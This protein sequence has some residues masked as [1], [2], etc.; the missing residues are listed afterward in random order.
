MKARLQPLYP[1]EFSSH[2]IMP[3]MSLKLGS[4]PRRLESR[5]LPMLVAF[6]AAANGDAW[7]EALLSAA[8]TDDTHEVWGI[9]AENGSALRATAIIAYLPF[10]AELQSIT[11]WP[12]ARRR[13]LAQGLLRWLLD[14]ARQRGVERLLL[15]VRESNLAARRLYERAGF[16]IDGQRR[17]YYRRADGGSEDAVLMSFELSGEEE[18]VEKGSSDQ[19]S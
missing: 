16:G 19:Q 18:G 6:E 8:L 14:R 9:W 3:A 12:Q 15:E 13:G 5:D 1:I 4:T 7:S 11:V 17:G 10:D 2:H